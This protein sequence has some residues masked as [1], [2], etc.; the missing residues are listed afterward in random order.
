MSFHHL[1][2]KVLVEVLGE[3]SIDNKQVDVMTEL[4]DWTKPYL[5][6]LHH[7]ILLVDSEEAREIKANVGPVRGE[8]RTTKQRGYLQLLLRRISRNEGQA[9]LEE[10]HSGETRANEEVRALIGKILSLGVY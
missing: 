1:T 4:P 2:K 9:L 7:E 5:D 8:R 10:S 6:Y 3:M